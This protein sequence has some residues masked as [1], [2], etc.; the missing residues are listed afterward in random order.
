M[1]L[2]LYVVRSLPVRQPVVKEARLPML[3]LAVFEGVHTFLSLPLKV[4]IV[5]EFNFQRTLSETYR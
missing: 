4:T 1:S 2:K 5:S 3:V